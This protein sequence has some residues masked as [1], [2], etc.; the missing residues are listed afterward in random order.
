MANSPTPAVTV[1]LIRRFNKIFMDAEALAEQFKDEYVSVEHIYL[2]LLGEKG[3]A[4]EKIFNK[5]GI[6]KDKFLSELTKVR[7]A[8]DLFS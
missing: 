7:G 3:T 8:F 6:T 2:A 1:P 4:S 5:Y